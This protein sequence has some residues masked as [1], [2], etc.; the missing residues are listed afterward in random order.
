[1]WKIM[2]NVELLQGKELT[3]GELDDT[4]DNYYEGKLQA[5]GFAC[6]AYRV[7]Q[8]NQYVLLVKCRLLQKDA[9]IRNNKV[10]IGE[11][12]AMRH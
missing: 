5:K 4:I 9:V 10:R 6:G 12:K 8:H 3:I 2:K 7:Y 11:M 1:M